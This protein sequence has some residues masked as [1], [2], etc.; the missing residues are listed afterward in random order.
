[1]QLWVSP[2]VELPE[3]F[4]LERLWTFT[5]FYFH[6]GSK[7]LGGL[8]K[9]AHGQILDL[10]IIESDREVPNLT[11]LFYTAGH[12]QG[13]RTAIHFCFFIPPLFETQYSIIL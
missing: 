1:M 5:D 6:R 12:S 10:T 3:L 11:P 7:R 4:L 13:Q 9:T 2:D 8:V